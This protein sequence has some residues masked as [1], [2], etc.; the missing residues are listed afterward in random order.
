MLLP[1]HITVPIREQTLC[2]A[3]ACFPCCTNRLRF[4]MYLAD[5]PIVHTLR[6][7]SQII[8]NK[9]KIKCHMCCM[10][11]SEMQQHNLV[12][13]AFQ[14]DRIRAD[15]LIRKIN[16]TAWKGDEKTFVCVVQHPPRFLQLNSDLSVTE[17]KQKQKFCRLHQIL[18]HEIRSM[19]FL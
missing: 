13:A 11:S 15:V 16:K 9:H 8:P 19:F 3:S 6:F 17:R 10:G 2:S 5:R 1:H 7:C 12:A 4:Q 14:V 18:L